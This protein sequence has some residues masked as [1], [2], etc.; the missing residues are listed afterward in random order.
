MRGSVAAIVAVV[1]WAFSATGGPLL[2]DPR[3]VLDI[4]EGSFRLF[5]GW[6]TPTLVTADGKLKPL[7]WSATRSNP[8]PKPVPVRHSWY[9]PKDWTQPDF[10]DTY[11]PRTRGPVI[12]PQPSRFGQIRSPGNPSEW[13]VICLRGRFTVR[14]PSKVVMLRVIL[15]YHGGGIVYVNG[16]ELQR[17]HLPQGEIN[18]ETLADRYPL[19]AY[20]RPDGRLYSLADSRDREFFDRF[21]KRVRRIPP[22]GWLNAVAIPNS[23]LRKGVNVVAIEVHAAPV[24]EIAVTG[25]TTPGSWKEGPCEWP[26]GG[27]VEAK[28]T[29][30]S[31]AGLLQ[32]VAPSRGIR[33][34]NCHPWETL[35]VYDYAHPAEKVR[36][37]R[38]VGAR[39]GIFS[40]RVM[41]SSREAVRQLRA[42]VTEL[43]RVG[44]KGKIP[45]EE[46]R[47][48]YAEPGN[49]GRYGR[50]AGLPHSWRGWRYWPRF[51]RLF[52]KAPDE[53]EA[54]PMPIRGRTLQPVP[55]VAVPVW[56]TVRVPAKAAPGSYEGK[57]T[58]EA[59]GFGP[60]DVPIRL[61]VHDWR[62]PDPKDFRLTH[63]IYQ[64]PDSVAMYYKVPRWSKKHFELMGKSLDVLAGIG[65]RI[66]VI[67]LMIRAPNLNN[68]DSMVRW[69]RQTDGSFK[70]DFSIMERY[71]DLYAQRVGKPRVLAIYNGHFEG[72]KNEVPPPKVSLLNPATGKLEPL[73]VPAYGTKENGQ[74]WKP[75]FGELRTR[76]EKRGWFDVAMLGHVSYCWAP[77]KETAQI[78]KSIWPDGMWISSCHGYRSGFG[79]RPVLCNEWIW[80]CGRLY[81]PDSNN[82]RYARYPRPW[83]RTR[84]GRPIMDLRIPR[85][86]LRD[87]HP[88]EAYR[89]AP[90]GMLQNSLH[91]LGRLGGDFWPLMN[92][93]SGRPYHLCDS[94]FALGH[95]IN[96]ISFISPGPDG[97]VS[98]ERTEAFREGVQ[99]AEAIAYVRQMLDEKKVAGD[100]VKRA[101]QFLDDRARHYLRV[102]YQ[103]SQHWLALASSGNHE[104][105]A[106]LYALAAEIAKKSAKGK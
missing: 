24:N 18:Y 21:A 30:A 88:I 65:S 28:V 77:T 99:I 41:V 19:E 33:V 105:D 82:P 37:I 36:P 61:E 63:N 100:V 39:N 81:N 78:Y 106:R 97:A 72:R 52:D 73:P 76:I 22:K 74:F 43:T 83:T 45:V 6:K 70:Y 1:G 38:L 89:A 59:E 64:S 11:W 54:E 67:P 47:V 53:I 62:V 34:S 40:G 84:S 57:L 103:A 101:E 69:I 93:K 14:D 96:V 94:G 91:G 2:N 31:P 46:I 12:V 25:K 32:N 48:R 8:N 20:V 95:A 13:N 51:D 23:V 3:L 58:V 35:L 66:C 26:H 98:N 29:A 55:T 75:V 79:G 27:I 90:E 71:L 80:G 60:L 104:R 56:V 44:G 7:R 42:R 86:S 9:P 10:N 92:S 102:G 87:N 16:K 49:R 15:R 17:G 85:G 68:T 5:M 4:N 50:P